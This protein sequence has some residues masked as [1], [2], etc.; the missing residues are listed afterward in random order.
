MHPL[1]LPLLAL[2]LAVSGLAG[3]QEEARPSPAPDKKTPNPALL[4][5]Q[6]IALLPEISPQQARLMSDVLA[7]KTPATGESVRP[8]LHGARKSLDRFLLAT[9]SEQACD[10]GT[11]FEEGPFAPMPHL[12]K[13]HLLCQV[14]LVQAASHFAEQRPDEALRVLLAVHRAARHVASDALMITL[15][16]QH[17]IE[18]QAIRLTA[19]HVLALTPPAR[20]AHLS[21]LGSLPPLCSVRDALSGEHSLSEWL[22][23]WVLGIQHAP[24]SEQ[25][26]LDAAR[27][28]L[29]SQHASGE[30]AQ[31]EAAKDALRQIDEWKRLAEEARAAQ[32]RLKEASQK[33]W[34]GFIADMQQVRRD[35]AQADAALRHTFPQV[36]GAMRKQCETA[37]LHTM[38]RLA[39]EQGAALPDG[40]LPQAKDAFEDL[41]LRV[42]HE[43]GARVIQAQP[44]IR[45]RRLSLRLPAP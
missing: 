30:A 42:L 6:A 45:G 7:Q 33:P 27:S 29:K 14:A 22:R 31:S 2:L 35:F 21:S 3:A 9:A 10:W 32:A 5:W 18:Q 15:V 11:T 44:E 28:L 12:P 20:A 41:P 19:Q 38:L 4:Y 1:R 39:L 25:A 13:M 37:T 26:M 43:D 23:H 17:S 36:E 40:E 16:S 24:E 34:R 8:L